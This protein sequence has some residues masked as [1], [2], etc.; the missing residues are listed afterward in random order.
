MKD[1]KRIQVQTNHPFGEFTPG[2]EHRVQQLPC[3]RQL[4]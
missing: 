4:L 3:M 1:N 2:G